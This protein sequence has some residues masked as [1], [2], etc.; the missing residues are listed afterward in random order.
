MEDFTNA[1]RGGY[2]RRAFF[3][4][5]NLILLFGAGAF[6]AASA[7]WAPLAMGAA[8]ELLWLLSAPWFPRSV[9]GSTR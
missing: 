4:Q 2:R 8:L 9:A 5:Y 6:A 7:S 1:F 3:L